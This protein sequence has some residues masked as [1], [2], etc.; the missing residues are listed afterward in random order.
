MEIKMGSVASCKVCQNRHHEYYIYGSL[1]LHSACPLI[2]PKHEAHLSACPLTCPKYEVR[3]CVHSN[4]QSCSSLICM[5]SQSNLAVYL[6]T[7]VM[8]LLLQSEH[9]VTT[10]VNIQSRYSWNESMHPLQS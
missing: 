1:Q 5:L 9:G 6:Q 3:H 2:F 7:Y 8:Q 10:F 4:F